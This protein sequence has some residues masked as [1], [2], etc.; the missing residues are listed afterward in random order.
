MH[1]KMLFTLLGIIFLDVLGDKTQLA[2]FAFAAESKS[3]L[4]VSLG[5]QVHLC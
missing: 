1:Y 2:A 4:A 3:R 5:R